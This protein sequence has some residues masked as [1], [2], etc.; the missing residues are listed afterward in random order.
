MRLRTFIVLCIALFNSLWL[1]HVF[2]V[3]GLQGE[4]PIREPISWVAWLEVGLCMVVAGLII[5]RLLK[6][7]EKK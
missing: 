5:E 2:I 3:L 1:A 7:K 4:Y 6:L